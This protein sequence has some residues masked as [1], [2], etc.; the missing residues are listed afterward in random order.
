MRKLAARLLMGGAV[1]LISFGIATAERGHIAFGAEGMVALITVAWMIYQV[2]LFAKQVDEM[3][4]QWARRGS[5]IRMLHRRIKNRDEQILCLNE[6]IIGSNRQI[7]KLEKENEMLQ[8]RER[9]LEGKMEEIDR[10]LAKMEQSVAKTEQSEASSGRDIDP[11][12]I[13][14]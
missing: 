13:A 11:E 12:R 9:F 14:G 5:Y 2:Y 3:E 6:S 1:I 8:E 10:L 7:L 4:I